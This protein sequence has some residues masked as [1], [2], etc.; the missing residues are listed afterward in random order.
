MRPTIA[1]WTRSSSGSPRLANL[2]ARKRARFS[3]TVTRRSR[4]AGS[5]VRLY[6]AK[7]S[8]VSSSRRR[9]FAAFLERATASPCDVLYH[10]DRVRA[11][12][13][14]VVRRHLVHQDPDQHAAQLDVVETAAA[15]HLGR[16]PGI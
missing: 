16:G 8:S 6:T 15:G 10:P 3:C 13:A 5:R 12:A 2:P 9:A 7:S 14:I 1:T 11:R 4:T